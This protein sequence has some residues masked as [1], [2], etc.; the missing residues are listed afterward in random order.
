LPTKYF[1]APSKWGRYGWW[2]AYIG[3]RRRNYSTHWR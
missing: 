2:Q 3:A 1:I